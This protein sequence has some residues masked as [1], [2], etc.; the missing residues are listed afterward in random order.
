VSLE[1]VDVV[2][3][4]VMTGVIG[5]FIVVACAATLHA[6][7]RSIEDASDAAR[8]LEPLAGE[9]A[10]TLFGAGLLGAALLAA[11]ILPLS[12]AYSVTEALGMEGSLDDPW[13]ESPLFHGT[14]VVIVVVAAGAV[15]LPG[16]PLVP[17]LFVTQALNA[18]LLLPL[19]VFIRGLSLDR[20]LMGRYAL[21]PAGA[22]LTAVAIAALAACVAA[23][24]VL[25]VTG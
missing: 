10:A 21:G 11:S 24:G 8:A 1:R 17:I 6:D 20:D 3:G 22:A 7:G 4:A 14:Y 25:T 16:A 23:L 18:I 12:T 15:L 19:L 2:A 9:L 13:R 5:V